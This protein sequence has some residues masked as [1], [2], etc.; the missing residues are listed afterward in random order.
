MTL[1]I[2][3]LLSYYMNVRETVRMFR[4]VKN[5]PKNVRIGCLGC[6]L[7]IF[8]ILICCSSIY[9]YASLGG[10][11]ASLQVIP[12]PPNS[13][14][15][16]ESSEEDGLYSV[17]TTIY[18]IEVSIGEVRTWFNGYI[19]MSPFNGIVSDRDKTYI[20]LNYLNTP[21]F[22]SET[23]YFILLFSASIIN[24]MYYDEWP[25]CFS[26]EIYSYDLF[27]NTDYFIQHFENFPLPASDTFAVVQR[28][29]PVIN[30]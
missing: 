19:F 21:K 5:T 6:I 25:S 16:F 29:W 12:I 13:R 27:I 26:V 28:C 7:P 9:I 4:Y 20:S 1:T 11:W 10:E 2:L 24:R 14:S 30:K 17:Q 18:A 3:H 15:I 22:D 8:L 23:E